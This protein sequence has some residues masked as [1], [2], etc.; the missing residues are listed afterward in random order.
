[1]NPQL[2]WTFLIF[3]STLTWSCSSSSSSSSSSSPSS[4]T[5][6]Y[7][8][9]VDDVKGRPY[10][11]TSFRGQVTLVVNVA[12]ECGFTDNHYH[13]LVKVR[14]LLKGYGFEVLAFPCNQFGGQEPNPSTMIKRFVQ[15]QYQVEFPVFHK[16]E[17]LGDKANEAFRFLVNASGKEPTWNFWK[18]LVNRDGSVVDAWGPQVRVFELYETLLNYVKEEANQNKIEL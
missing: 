15:S 6:F 8:F 5:D 10:S 11:L 18:Y 16:I 13:E 17:V 7:S 12:S 4:H 1:M 2:I 14:E 9:I 3:L